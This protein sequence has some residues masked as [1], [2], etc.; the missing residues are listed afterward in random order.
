[1]IAAKRPRTT[2]ESKLANGLLLTHS[3][4]CSGTLTGVLLGVDV[5]TETPSRS[6]YP[7][8]S[9][10]RRPS[11]DD[12]GGGIYE[13]V[14]RSGRIVKLTPANFSTSGAIDYPI[15]PPLNFHL[16]DVLGWKQPE[17]VNSVVR[18]YAIDKQVSSDSDDG[19]GAK[20]PV[21]DL[22]LY[23]VTG[24]VQLYTCM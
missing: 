1:M 23:P 11:D 12:D 8:I 4:S 15:D 18:M 21:E 14:H 7:E 13:Q 24:E 20:L 16:G 10:W 5:R 9:L 17:I 19:G 2:I 22:L 6:L 3:F